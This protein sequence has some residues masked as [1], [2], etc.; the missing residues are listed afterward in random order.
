M[1]KPFA[2]NPRG[3]TERTRS[4]RCTGE[5]GWKIFFFCDGKK[6]IIPFS[7]VLRKILLAP[8][9]QEGLQ[10]CRRSTSRKCLEVSLTL[11]VTDG[12]SREATSWASKLTRSRVS[13]SISW[14]WGSWKFKKDSTFLNVDERV[15]L[16]LFERPNLKKKTNHSHRARGGVG[17]V[18]RRGTT[19]L[20]KTD[21]AWITYLAVGGGGN[22]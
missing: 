1:L 18:F 4:R 15:F 20:K 2:A 19:F 7:I 6:S 8:N 14:P 13:R 17:D 10:F 11:K 5:I 12:F 22:S 16:E 21:L 3:N 9:S